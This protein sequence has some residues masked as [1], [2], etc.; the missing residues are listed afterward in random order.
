MFDACMKHFLIIVTMCEAVEALKP[1]I[2]VL[3]CQPFRTKLYHFAQ[4]SLPRARIKHQTTKNEI[5]VHPTDHGNA[6]LGPIQ[7]PTN[8]PVALVEVVR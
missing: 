5:V 7:Q 2:F 3:N 4:N 6:H 1:D 8:N